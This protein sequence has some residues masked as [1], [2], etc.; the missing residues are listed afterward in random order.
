VA[1]GQ[2]ISGYF[3]FPANL[4]STKFSIII[5]IQG[6]Y[7]RPISA[8]RA[9]WTQLDSTPTMRIKKKKRQAQFQDLPFSSH[10]STPKYLHRNDEGIS[11]EH[12][13]LEIY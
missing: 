3:S 1:L 6:M 4:H 9:E 13:Q 12:S 5:I 8:H 10:L 11:G 7:K 2:V